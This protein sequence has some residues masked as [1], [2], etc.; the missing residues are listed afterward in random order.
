MGGRHRAPYLR[1]L[2][3]L[4][5]GLRAKQVLRVPQAPREILDDRA[6]VLS[7]VSSLTRVD[8]VQFGVGRHAKHTIAH[9]PPATA[10][11]SCAYGPTVAEANSAGARIK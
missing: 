4:L 6:P 11:W 10:M 7:Q 5:Q 3:L 8:R 9:V 2:G 1:G